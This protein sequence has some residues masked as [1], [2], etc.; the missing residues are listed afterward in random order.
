MDNYLSHIVNQ[1]AFQAQSPTGIK[2]VQT[3]EA[4]NKTAK[5]FE[6]MFMGQM[7]NL[8]FEDV[9]S[10]PLFGDKASDKIYRSMLLEQYGKEM[11]ESSSLGI[12]DQVRGELLKLQE[13]GQ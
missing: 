5:E 7:L 9:P 1:T 10:D 13:V 12:A 11:A 3:P 4:I 8:M 2:N 6:S